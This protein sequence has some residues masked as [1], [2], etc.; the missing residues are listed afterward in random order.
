MS[1]LLRDGPDGYWSDALPPSRGQ[2][3]DL[4]LLACDLLGIE[5]PKTRLEATTAQ[6][7]LRAAVAEQD[8]PP[9]GA[10][11]VATIPS[12][13][14]P[15]P[16]LA[17][18]EEDALRVVETAASELEE[19]R[20]ARRRRS[21][22]VHVRCKGCNAFRSSTAGRCSHCGFDQDTGWAA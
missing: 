15:V 8:P 20:L 3:K 2:Y 7:R 1:D 9:E 19:R 18:S 5:R 11:A 16:A 4:A 12:R 6:V 13:L 14:M 22:G 17:M 10:R 21:Q